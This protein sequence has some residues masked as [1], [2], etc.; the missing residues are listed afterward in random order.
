MRPIIQ[1]FNYVRSK[2]Y[3]NGAKDQSCTVCDMND[4]TTVFV[5]LDAQ[6]AGKGRGIKADDVAGFDGCQECHDRYARLDGNPLPEWLITRA[7]YRTVKRRI[8]Q[9]ILIIHD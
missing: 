2:T 9:G 8:E 6:Y 1:K 5:H 4:G 3:R 7:L